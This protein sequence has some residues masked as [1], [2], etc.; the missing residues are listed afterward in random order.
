MTN[1]TQIQTYPSLLPVDKYATETSRAVSARATVSTGREKSR[2]RWRPRGHHW[3]TPRVPVEAAPASVRHLGADAATG[4]AV[5]HLVPAST[6]SLEPPPIWDRCVA[7]SGSRR[8]HWSHLRA[9]AAIGAISETPPC[10]LR[11][12]GAATAIGAISELLP[13]VLQNL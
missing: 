12:L 10:V 2:R 11:H 9:T 4:G 3:T 5:Q 13:C 6:T 7:Q 1:Y 8:R